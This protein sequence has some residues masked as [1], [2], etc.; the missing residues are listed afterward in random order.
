[1]FDLSPY[2]GRTAKLSDY[3]LWGALVARGIV[4]NKDGAFQRTLM[5]RGPDLDSSSLTEL[6]GMSSR[7]ANALRRFGSGWCLHAE[8]RRRP[9]PG[10][11]D[12]VFVQGLAWLIDEERRV[13]FETA[14]ARFET[15]YFLTLTFLP[16]PEKQARLE[17]LLFEGGTSNAPAA[18][19][20]ALLARFAEETD[21]F[22]MAFGT[23]MP[24][25]RWLDDEATLGFLHDAVSD[26]RLTR[27][28][29][30]PTP[31]HLAE[32][33]SDTPLVGGLAPKLGSHHLRILSVRSYVSA[34][35]PGLLDA[36]NRLPVSYRWVTRFLPLSAEE[37][38]QDIERARKR[39]FSKRKG[40]MTLLR[41]ALFREESALQD[42]DAAAQA[43]DADAALQTLLGEGCGAG[44]ATLTVTVAEDSEAAADEAVRLIRQ[45]T[46]TLGFVTELETVNAVEA[47]LGSLPGQAYADVRRPLLLAPN[48]AHLL[49]TSAV[50]PG[51][52]WNAHLD[53]PPLM[54]AATDGSTPF[55]LNL[56]AGDTGH[57][58]VIGPTGA[59]KS[60]L[61]ATLIAQ[62]MRYENAQVFVFD[63][64]RSCRAMVLGLGGVFFDPD[65]EGAGPAPGF[66]P[67]AEI[68]QPQT[69]AWAE[70]WLCDLIAGE[71]VKLTP[72]L[73]L[74][75]GRA[76]SVLAARPIRERT[77][78]LLAA[79]V[80]DASLRGALQP[81]THAGSLGGLLDQDFEVRSDADVTAFEVGSLLRQ[82]RAARSVLPVIFRSLEARFDGRPSLLVLDE[83]WLYLKD[84]AF[85][86]EIE[87]WLKTLRKQNV[88]V[89]FASQ[90][91][92]DVTR[93][94]IAASV[95]ENCPT[96]I[97]LPNDRA[98][99]A[100]TRAFY[101]AAGLNERQIDLVAS[102]IPKR[103]YYVAGRAGCRRIEL[104]LGPATFAFA[105]A[106]KPEDQVLIDRILALHGPQGFAQAWLKAKGFGEAA[107]AI[108]R[109]EAVTKGGDA[110]APASLASQAQ[111]DH[112]PT[113]QRPS[114]SVRPE[115]A[116]A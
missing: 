24:E 29:V 74:E 44:Y 40:L 59:G 28:S 66:Q 25:A 85:A 51:E 14:G 71:G 87:T 89:I 101:E 8:A 22:R 17:S 96:R 21:Q 98:R 84:T 110:S 102:A 23:L 4:L 109:F 78:S 46:D 94:P 77:L 91:L 113:D 88:A 62:W 61:I 93:S 97:F 41:E 116:A 34:S 103:D 12:A 69:R 76:L 57:T 37:A 56:H 26:R 18:D 50:W 31:F 63:T 115:E 10:Y 45:T 68:N 9:A 15:D 20:R 53:G 35:E 30:P 80:Q 2:R 99:E 70:S 7:L 3:L 82:P 47:W 111:N 19:Y 73:R 106:G 86:A 27:L 108:G 90:A 60:V 6:M 13:L 16:P 39:W 32:L 11:P 100:G 104:E 58:L 105:A 52:A 112:T 48:L 95:L 79:F 67:L 107:A 81:F 38:R 72:E 54:L 75:L 1:M 49:P 65:A 36:L 114:G 5:F 64:G 92:A 55:R 42:N 83:A 33:L 43:G